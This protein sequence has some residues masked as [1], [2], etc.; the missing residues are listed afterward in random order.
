MIQGTLFNAT[1]ATPS[2]QPPPDISLARRADP[3][4][5]HKAAAKAQAVRSAYQERALAVF[6]DAAGPL[7]AEEVAVLCI[8]RFFGEI[9]LMHSDY[10]R[11][12]DNHRKRA[13]EVARENQCIEK[14]DGQRRNGAQLF[15]F[16]ETRNVQ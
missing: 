16:R 13:H 8:S 5:S 14:L 3:E 12:C 1:P 7:T 15:Q 6:R 9:T 11:L 4:T 2:T 10:R